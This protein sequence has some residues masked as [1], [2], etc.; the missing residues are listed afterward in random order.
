MCVRSGNAGSKRVCAS[1]HSPPVARLFSE[2]AL[3]IYTQVRSINSCNF[4]TPSPTVVLPDFSIFANLAG[5][6]WYLII[7]LFWG[8]LLEENLF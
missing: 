8:F 1:S 4:Y 6:R 7:A 2:A 3:P 5:G